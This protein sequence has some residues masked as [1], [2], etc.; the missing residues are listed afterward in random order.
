MKKGICLLLTVLMLLSGVTIADE[1]GSPEMCQHVFE[2]CDS[3]LP[4]HDGSVW[5]ED[6]GAF[7]A[8]AVCMLCGEKCVVAKDEAT[9]TPDPCAPEVCTHRLD[10]LPDFTR[11]ICQAGT[12]STGEAMHQQ[13]K[14]DVGVCVDCG[15]VATVIDR[16]E[17]SAHQMVEKNGFHVE[18]QYIHVAC[19]ECVLCGYMT[20]EFVP[21]VSYEDGTCDAMLRK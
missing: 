14:Y 13:V 7:R 17:Y 18:G 9:L 1:S 11:E 20:G 19:Q 6:E 4:E 10:T 2:L 8:S 5:T 16:L 15:I 21:C 12:D 3:V